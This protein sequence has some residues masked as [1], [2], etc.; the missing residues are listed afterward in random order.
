MNAPS[1]A[2]STLSAEPIPSFATPA[3]HPAL[4]NE[5]VLQ[6]H[7]K[8]IPMFVMPASDRFKSDFEAFR[9]W[10]VE[11]E[12]Q[13]DALLRTYGAL[14]FRGFPIHGT[15]SFAAM[16]AHYPPAEMGYTGGGTPRGAI[17]GRVFEST[18]VDPQYS[19]RLHQEMSYLPH[20]PHKL[21]FYSKVAATSG[22]AT[23][24]CDVRL[25]QALAPKRLLEE[26]L[27]RGVMYR[28][29]FRDGSRPLDGWH[30]TLAAIHRSWQDA[31]GSEDKTEVQEKLEAMGLSWEWLADGS[32]Q[33][34]YCNAGYVAHPVTGE[35]HWFNQINQYTMT[36]ADS[37]WNVAAAHYGEDKPWYSEVRYGDGERIAANELHDLRRTNVLLTVD[38]PWQEGEV[39]VLDNVLCCHGRAPYEGKR[40]VQVQLFGSGKQ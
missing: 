38:E 20:W 32:L 23:S 8:G 31:F 19:I 12:T 7:P 37:F 34:T 18:R 3:K 39:M 28:R 27:K 5:V 21:A 33:T 1:H 29:N 2:N 10:F 35:L 6:L 9:Q 26:V 30:P 16:T 25:V 14:R 17:A 11:H 4:G 24:I 40:D 36:E 13:I 22:G 15:D